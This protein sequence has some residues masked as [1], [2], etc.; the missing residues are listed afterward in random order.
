MHEHVAREV[1]KGF[2]A[3]SAH[4]CLGAVHLLAVLVQVGLDKELLAAALAHEALVTM[5]E[6]VVAQCHA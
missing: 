2:G 3:H 6:Q 4:A 1:G 5:R